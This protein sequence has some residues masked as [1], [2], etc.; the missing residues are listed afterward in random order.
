MD[1]QAGVHWAATKAKLPAQY[2][3]YGYTL[4]HSSRGLNMIVFAVGGP[5]WDWQ[6]FVWVPMQLHWQQ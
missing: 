5:D 6:F 3:S 2:I 4:P 1:V